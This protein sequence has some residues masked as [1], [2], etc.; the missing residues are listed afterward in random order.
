MDLS[1]EMPDG[2]LRTK[3]RVAEASID[4]DSLPGPAAPSWS[5]SSSSPCAAVDEVRLR[6][7]LDAE[8]NGDGVRTR[9][10]RDL[11]LRELRPLLDEEAALWQDE[12]GWDFSDVRAPVAA[13]IERRTLP[14]R[15]VTEARRAVAY[16]YYM[17]DAGG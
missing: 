10:L 5:A 1:V 16:C 13:G 7:F 15:V 4:G 9:P 14:G 2:P 8:R 3:A 11:S 12:L 6:S 17:V